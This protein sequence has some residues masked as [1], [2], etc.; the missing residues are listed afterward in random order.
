M[1]DHST[2]VRNSIATV[3]GSLLKQEKG[4]ARE[5]TLKALYK[6]REY[7]NTHTHM[8]VLARVHAST[9]NMHAL[10]LER[11]HEIHVQWTRTL[12]SYP[13]PP[14]SF[15]VGEAWV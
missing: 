11:M 10:T 13:S 4:T 14:L 5:L 15:G 3:L 12:A 6:A 8:R 2:L 9:Q 7:S 1:L